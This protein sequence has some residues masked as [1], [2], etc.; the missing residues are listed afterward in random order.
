MSQTFDVYEE[1]EHWSDS[2]KPSNVQGT[3]LTGGDT[4][5]ITAGSGLGGL[6]AGEVVAI[7]GVVIGFLFGLFGFVTY[8]MRGYS[9]L[10]KQSVKTFV[11]KQ[12]PY[13]VRFKDLKSHLSTIDETGN[14]ID[15]SKCRFMAECTGS[16]IPEPGCIVLSANHTVSEGASHL[17]EPV[18]VPGVSHYHSCETCGHIMSHIHNTLDELIPPVCCCC[19]DYFAD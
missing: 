3:S 1:S 18:C 2:S 6:S 7:V 9:P 13:V 16:L 8:K 15:D 10:R 5:N 17:N 11:T 12:V 14:L 19:D 4:G